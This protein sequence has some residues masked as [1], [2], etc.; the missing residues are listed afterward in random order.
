MWYSESFIFLILTMACGG[1]MAVLGGI[2]CFLLALFDK[3]ESVGEVRVGKFFNVKGVSLIML[4]IVGVALMGYSVYSW[5]Q[6]RSGD[7][8]YD[9]GYDAGMVW[10]DDAFLHDEEA[11]T[12]PVDA[13]AEEPMEELELPVGDDDDSADL[14]V[15]EVLLL[16]GALLELEYLE[17]DDDDAVEVEEP[18]E[19]HLIDDFYLEALGRKGS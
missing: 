5:T 11:V 12:V 10:D 3:D 1:G 9:F 7:G 17:G 15:F 16:E 4:S 18:I 13:P 14:E 19:M 6:I 2:G 8:G